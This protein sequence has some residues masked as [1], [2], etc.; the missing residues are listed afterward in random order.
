MK[1]SALLAAALAA[2]LPTLASG[3]VQT[4]VRV[5]DQVPGMGAVTAVY[6]V[7]VNDAGDW[8]AHVLTD[9]PNP[10]ADQVILLDGA[11]YLREGD[12]LPGSPGFFTAAVN[13]LSFNAGGD[14]AWVQ[15]SGSDQESALF[16]DQ[17]L[18]A[19]FG[20]AVTA[21]GV[22]PG[23]TFG[24][25]GAAV[26]ND[27]RQI[28]AMAR[29]REPGDPV[30]K[31]SIVRIQVDALGAPQAEEIV[32]QAGLLLPW[33][34]ALAINE[35]GDA[36]STAPISVYLNDT[37]LAQ[38]GGLSPVFGQVWQ[39]LDARADVGDGGDHAYTGRIDGDDVVV[40]NG[41]LAAREGQVITSFAP[42][43]LESLGFYTESSP[44]C[45]DASG[46]LVWFAD[47]NDPDTRRDTAIMR[48]HEILVQEGV[49]VAGGSTLQGIGEGG[50]G[51]ELSDNGLYLVF[52]ATDA[53]GVEAAYM[54]DVSPGG[55]EL[56][57]AC[58]ANPADLSA[59]A[60]AAPDGSATFTLQNPQSLAALGFVGLA[61]QKVHGPCG[62]VFPGLGEVLLAS[63]S[64]VVPAGQ[65]LPGLYS[66]AIEIPDTPALIGER[67]FAQGLFLDASSPAE[68]LRLTRQAAEV[69]IG[70][71]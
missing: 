44:V 39:D 7:T 59:G 69:H 61:T 65:V 49:S 51:Y 27:A 10:G 30:G 23:T 37:V 15:N 5:G 8:L 24:R 6:G 25:F 45:V 71:K 52:L 68:P 58:A 12:P 55:V 4:L 35:S 11:I 47:W 13:I 18:V 43:A 60:A 57:L 48:D 2:A 29:I 26:L 14:T 9:H 67:F 62:V 42:F 28:L 38:V 3:Q 70:P 21:P 32:H 41:I 22:V 66:A 50:H 1:T 46:R 34:I 40:W 36:A 54:L 53:A 17:A 19:Q 56:H 33:D 20:D 63:V 31:D 16:F 64:A